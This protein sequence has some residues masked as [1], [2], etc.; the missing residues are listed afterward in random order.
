V[1]GPDDLLLAALRKAWGQIRFQHDL[2][3]RP[4]LLALHDG[5]GQLGFWRAADRT[6]SLSRPHVL[7]DPWLD[8][9]ET[10]LH[11]V[12]HQV[13]DEIHGGTD[14][15]HGPLFQS[16]LRELGALPGAPAEAP[17]VVGRVRKLLALAGSANRHEAELAMVKAQQ[18]MI[19]HRLDQVGLDGER[20]YVRRQLGTPALRQPR[21]RSVL[22]A[23]VAR[24]FFT[25]V[26]RTQVYLREQDRWGTVW[27]IVGR[28]EDV[29]M[30]QY[31]FTFVERTAEGLWQAHRAAN[32]ASRARARFLLGVV[33]GFDE[34]LQAGVEKAT[35]T[36]LV[37][38]GDPALSA[39]YVRRYPRTTSARGTYRADGHFDAGRQAGGQMV[40]HRPIG[41]RGSGGGLLEG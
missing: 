24:H 35:S 14:R 29:D 36:G 6:L 21:W 31:A 20:G 41:T 38:V 15:P 12:A 34:R 40:L 32:P 19:R 26:I 2:D 28:P 17:A 10:V 18:L 37:L 5:R 9:H 1:S 8:V 3:L 11:E 27:E 25:E 33:M 30:A 7:D 16:V 13:V 23:S 22:A 4:P 39:A